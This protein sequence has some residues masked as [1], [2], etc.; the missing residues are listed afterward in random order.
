MGSYPNL[1]ALADGRIPQI[2]CWGAALRQEAEE[3]MDELERLRDL[4]STLDRLHELTGALDTILGTN[5]GCCL[6][7][8]GDG[9]EC[10]ASRDGVTGIGTGATPAEAILQAGR[11]I[12]G[13]LA[14]ARE[15]A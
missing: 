9:V 10:N 5:G 6:F 14:L 1:D 4:L 3:A 2:R 13:L 8:E 7:R 12:A 11:N 15:G